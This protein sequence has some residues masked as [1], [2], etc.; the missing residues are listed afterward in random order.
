MARI[1]TQI[2]SIEPARNAASGNASDLSG[3]AALCM[4][5]Y[6][7]LDVAVKETAVC[8]VDETGRILPR[9]EGGEPSAGSGAG[10]Q[11]HPPGG[12]N[13]RGL[14]PGLCRCSRALTRASLPVICIETRHIKAFLKA[15]VN[16]TEMMARGA[17]Q[18]IAGQ[19]VSPGACEDIDEP[20]A[21][22]AADRPQALTGK[23]HRD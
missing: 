22:G 20:E 5:H 4:K 11:G 17:A 12:L 13:G 9:G 23:G 2:S 14:K 3:S 6:A 7:A 8:I 16:K 15:Q 10:V 1:S 18:M 21:P 19:P